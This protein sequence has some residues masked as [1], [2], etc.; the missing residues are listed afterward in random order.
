LEVCP[1]VQG[2]PRGRPLVRQPRDSRRNWARGPAFP[3]DARP[4]FIRRITTTEREFSRCTAL[5]PSR[6]SVLPG[7]RALTQPEKFAAREA[8]SCQLL[9]SREQR[10]WSTERGAK[11]RELRAAEN[12]NRSSQTLRPCGHTAHGFAVCRVAAE[13][14]QSFCLAP[15]RVFS[16]TSVASCSKSAQ[17]C[18]ANAKHDSMVQN[19]HF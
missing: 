10:A 3:I 4:G 15:C 14:A 9:A 5:R 12:A 18:H 13:R 7:P 16:A 8:V 6:R 19:S 17:F 11:S 1:A 2:I